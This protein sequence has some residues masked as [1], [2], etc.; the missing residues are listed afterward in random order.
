MRSLLL[1]PVLM[2]SAC[3]GDG[4]SRLSTAPPGVNVAQAA[5]AAGAPEVALNV[6]NGILARE[7]RK[8]AALLSQADALSALGRLDEADASYSKLLSVDPDS[9]PAMIGLGRLR[10]R[11]DAGQAKALFQKALQREP[12]NTIALNDLG[13]ALDLQGDHAAAQASYRRVLGLDPRSRAAEINLALSMAL[14]G[15]ASDAIQMLRPYAADAASDRRA[16]HNLAAAMAMAGDRD[17]AAR[18]LAQDLP[19]EQVERALQAYQAFAP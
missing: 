10:L 14:G 6:S 15:R 5:L 16:R 18:L 9:V 2:L 19:P 17:G 8:A 11:T 1:I 4:P 12:R 13:I 3:A 7:P